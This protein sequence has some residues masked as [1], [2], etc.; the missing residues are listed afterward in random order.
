[1]FL[2]PVGSLERGWPDRDGIWGTIIAVHPSRGLEG[3][4]RALG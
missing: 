3:R 1:M 4:L 2:E